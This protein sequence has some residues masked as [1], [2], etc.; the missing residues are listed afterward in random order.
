MNI[1]DIISNLFEIN[2][3]QKYFTFVEGSPKNI[4]DYNNII[5][6]D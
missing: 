1:C 2:H 3:I 6:N 5:I 4:I